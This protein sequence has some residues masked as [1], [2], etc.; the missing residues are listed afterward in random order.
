MSRRRPD[1]VGWD[2]SVLADL[3]TTDAKE[4]V[5]TVLTNARRIER[6]RTWTFGEIREAI[7]RELERRAETPNALNLARVRTQRGLAALREAG[8]IQKSGSG[9]RFP[10]R[11]RYA[12]LIAD[13]VRQAGK[14]RARLSV[15]PKFECL[16]DG[17][18]TVSFTITFGD[19]RGGTFIS[20]RQPG[21]VET[22]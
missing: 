11:Q 15:E 3:D 8:L 22:A 10:K 14:S 9:Y 6:T 13:M 21:T 5:T 2:G 1:L 19:P 4:W 17:S 7:R 12:E 20:V 18:H 16:P